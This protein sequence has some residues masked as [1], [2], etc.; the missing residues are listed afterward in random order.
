MVI[1]S[2]MVYLSTVL[3]LKLK[4]NYQEANLSTD[5]ENDFQ[6]VLRK[7]VGRSHSS[8]DLLPKTPRA[9][10]PHSLKSRHGKTVSAILHGKVF[11]THHH[12]FLKSLGK[13]VTPKKIHP[14][15][16]K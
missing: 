14:E 3:V 4:K 5:D 10:L 16:L 13:E 7:P 6:T 2:V 9:P 1:F 15:A 8:S 11:N 12:D